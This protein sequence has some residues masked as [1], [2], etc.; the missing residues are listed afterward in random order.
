MVISC[1]KCINFQGKQ[2]YSFPGQLTCTNVQE[3]LLH[4]TGFDDPISDRKMLKFYV[5]GRF[6]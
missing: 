2:F 1:G 5:K 6:L 4:Y 3:E